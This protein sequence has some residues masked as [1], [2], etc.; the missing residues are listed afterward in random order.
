MI[1]W[2][3][4]YLLATLVGI[5]VSLATRPAMIPV[6]QA[7]MLGI[8]LWWVAGA[9]VVGRILRN[10]GRMLERHSD[11]LYYQIVRK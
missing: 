11:W 5:I 4:A 9:D 3:A 7:V 2:F 10:G 8:V 6:R 1:Y